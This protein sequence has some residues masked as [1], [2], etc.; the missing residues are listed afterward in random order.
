MESVRRDQESSSDQLVATH[1]IQKGQRM[2]LQE[3]D[4]IVHEIRN[5]SKE[6]GYR[7]GSR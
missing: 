6:K 5:I 7:L 3:E 4:P 2:H 1:Y